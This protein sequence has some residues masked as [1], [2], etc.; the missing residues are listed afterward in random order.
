MHSD[1]DELRA[2]VADLPRPACAAL[3]PFEVLEA[4]N[5]PGH[6]RL[7]FE[8]QPA[9]ENHFGNVQGGFSVAMLDVLLSIA[10]YLGSGRFLP[11]IELTTNFLAPVPIDQI[12]GEGTVLRAG[13]SMVFAEA[14]LYG[15]SGGLAVHATGTALVQPELEPRS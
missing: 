9:F 3:T 5:D 15:P 4:R 14:S 2:H 6:V 7:R 1:G 10:V 11:T 13:A 8:P 12:E